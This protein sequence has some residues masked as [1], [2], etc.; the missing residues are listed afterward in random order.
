LGVGD[1]QRRVGE[2]LAV[3]MGVVE[4]VMMP[5]ADEHQVP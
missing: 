5:G 1:L 4:E 2:E 3:P